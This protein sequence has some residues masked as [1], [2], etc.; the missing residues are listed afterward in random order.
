MAYAP[1]WLRLSDA[2]QRVMNTGRSREEAQSDICRAIADQMVK[3]RVKLR[4]H[5]SRDQKYDDVLDGMDFV[6]PTQIIPADLDWDNSR[7]LRPW[8]VH[9]KVF[10]VPGYWEL[11]WIELSRT[12]VEEVLC[13]APEHGRPVQRASKRHRRSRPASERAKAAMDELYPAGVPSPAELPTKLLCKAINEKLREKGL[14]AVSVATI[15]RG[16]RRR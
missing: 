14:L 13:A 11:E 1:P 10:G 8:A 4:R 16:R 3:F 6:I 9:Y 15:L 2:L 12:D 7:P 5:V